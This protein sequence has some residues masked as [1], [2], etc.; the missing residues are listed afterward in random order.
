MYGPLL[1]PWSVDFADTIQDA[2]LQGGQKFNVL[3]HGASEDQMKELREKWQ[4]GTSVLHF[5]Q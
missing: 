2:V 3:V 5:Q 1:G 4:E